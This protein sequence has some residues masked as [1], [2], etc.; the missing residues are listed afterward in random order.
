MIGKGQT[1][2]QKRH[3]RVRGK[4]KGTKLRPRLSVF[5]SNQ[6]IYAQIV[7]DERDHTIVAGSDASAEL[8][9]QNE[10]LTKTEIARLVGGKLAENALSAGVKTVVFDRGGYKYHGRVKALAEG[11]REGGLKF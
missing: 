4:V 1:Q 6:H 8:K 7:D 3:T 9:I 2:R 11:A 5:R 10:K